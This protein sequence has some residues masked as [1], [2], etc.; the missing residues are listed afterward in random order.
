MDKDCAAIYETAFYPDEPSL[1]SALGLDKVF[2][3]AFS[4][5]RII[6]K[7]GES[8]AFKKILAGCPQEITT[9]LRKGGRGG[10]G[11]SGWAGRLACEAVS[12]DFQS[13]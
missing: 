5:E 11:P 2:L 4:Q 9:I 6:L 1:G 3:H 13:R 12:I 10:E 7:P 8:L